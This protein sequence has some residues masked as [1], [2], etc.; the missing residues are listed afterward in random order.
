MHPN[1]THYLIKS[2][3]VLSKNEVDFLSD[4]FFNAPG[5]AWRDCDCEEEIGRH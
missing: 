5:A 2:H 3:L 4:V 1:P